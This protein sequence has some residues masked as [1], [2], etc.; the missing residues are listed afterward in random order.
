MLEALGWMNHFNKSLF[1]T[2]IQ[3]KKCLKKS[4][5]NEEAMK[6]AEATEATETQKVKAE[7]RC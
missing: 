2:F 6:P 1:D 5:G 7:T 4:D 3:Q